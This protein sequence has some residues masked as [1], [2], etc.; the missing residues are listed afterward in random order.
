MLTV[1]VWFLFVAMRYKYKDLPHVQ[2]GESFDPVRLA[3]TMGRS[4]A[5]HGEDPDSIALL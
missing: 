3:E 4:V 2:E 1:F 5:Y